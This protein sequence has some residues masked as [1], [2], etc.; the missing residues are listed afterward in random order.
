MYNLFDWPTHKHARLILVAVA[1]TMDLPERVLAHRVSSRLGL[2]RL[3]FAPYTR[4]Q[5]VEILKA[6][7]EGSRAISGDALQLCARKVCLSASLDLSLL[8]VAPVAPHVPTTHL[9]R[10]PLLPTSRLRRFR[11]MRVAHWIFA[12]V[13]RRL[14][15]LLGLVVAR[16]VRVKSVELLRFSVLT[17]PRRVL[18]VDISHV[19]DAL[20]EMSAS[21]MIAAMRSAPLHAQLFLIAVGPQRTLFAVPAEVNRWVLQTAWTLVSWSSW[22]LFSLMASF[23]EWARLSFL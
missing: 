4:Q 12:D 7:V 10:W 20:Q 5:L 22:G 3:T 19:N 1:N 9:T 23:L 16:Y 17:V 15:R 8:L 2:T 21:P 11:E 18:Q 13:Q 14:P 6:R